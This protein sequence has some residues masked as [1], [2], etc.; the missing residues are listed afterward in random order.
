MKYAILALACLCGCA[1]EES[2]VQPQT[3]ERRASSA[4]DVP[5]VAYGSLVTVTHD[6]HQF[7]VWQQSGGVAL[8]H[9]P[10]CSCKKGAA[11]E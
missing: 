1:S 2:V 5:R 9:H 4:T 3:V 7:V 8:L 6:G 11:D 10:S